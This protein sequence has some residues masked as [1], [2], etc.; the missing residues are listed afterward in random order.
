LSHADEYIHGTAGDE[1]A[2]LSRLNE[3]LN[4]QSL[5][6]LGLAPGLRVLDVGSGLGQFARAMARV[7]GRGGCV[8]GVER[9]AV[10]T[11]TA[12]QL[13]VAAGEADL[14]DARAGDA[15]RLPLRDDEWGSFDVAHARFLLE[16][17][18]EPQAVVDAMVRAVRPGGRVVLEDDDHELLRLFPALPDLDRVW[19]AYATSYAVVGH[20]PWVGRKLPSLLA[21]AGAT[22]TRCDWPF[23]G[24]CHGSENFET[25]VANC[26]SILTGARE[27]IRAAGVLSAADFELGIR[28][29]DDWCR[30]PGAAYW[31]CTFWAEGV[32]P[33]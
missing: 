29:F 14:V 6:R 32:R 19:N 31:Y 30:T 1:Q 33:I 12:R 28:A 7:V 4:Q 11:A 16:H 26:R 22:P 15:H 3:L 10:Q 13:A 20:D 27:T 2:R 18:A 24:A 21:R 23:F 25:I 5:S 9:S 8:V 17:V